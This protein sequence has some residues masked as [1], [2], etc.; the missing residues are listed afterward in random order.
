MTFVQIPAAKALEAGLVD[1]VAAFGTSDIVQAATA[2]A[3]RRLPEVAG[4]LT[5][6][7]TR[8]LL[9]KVLSSHGL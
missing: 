5:A 1:H 6:L 3:R 9:L 2:F 4:G 7:R 8:N